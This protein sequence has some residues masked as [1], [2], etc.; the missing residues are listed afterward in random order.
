MKMKAP[1]I[2]MLCGVLVPS[3]L[4]AQGTVAHGQFCATYNDDA[5]PMNCS[6][7]TIEMCEESVSGVGGYCAPQ[8]L[9]PG[10][11]PPPLFK[12]FQFPSAFAPTPVLPPPI[13]P[14]AA[15]LP[16]NDN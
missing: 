10:M 12:P 7:T 6:F 1:R 5:T 11:P 3:M 14:A 15:P 8:S 4:H 9:A 2:M 13:N 16:Q